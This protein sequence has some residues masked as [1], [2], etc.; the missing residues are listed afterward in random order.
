MTNKCFDTLFGGPPRKPAVWLT[1]RDMDLAA[2][3]QAVT[4][5]VALR[6]ARSLL[7][8]QLAQHSLPVNSMRTYRACR[9]TDRTV[10]PVLTSGPPLSSATLSSA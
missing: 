10:C 3:I 7:V 4:E 5:E 9:P 6:L 1:Q 2:L 8:A